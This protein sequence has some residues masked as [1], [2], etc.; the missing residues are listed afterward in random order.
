[1]TNQLQKLPQR[2][3]TLS[4]FELIQTMAPVI[5][6]SRIYGGMVGSPNQAAAIMMTGVSY[7]FDPMTSFRVIHMIEGKPS[8]APA[9][10]LALVQNS[11]HLEAMTVEDIND[12]QGNPWA[13]RVMMKR[14]G[15]DPYTITVTLDDARRAGLT[16]GSPKGDGKARGRGNWEKYPANMLRWRAIGFVSDVLFADVLTNLKRG[17]EMG[18]NISAEGDFIDAESEVVDE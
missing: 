15:L 6:E 17:D 9:G 2:E 10:A 13:C 18:A 3:L 5:H 4:L 12:A 8:I 11:G 1:M 14:H 16:E 7:G